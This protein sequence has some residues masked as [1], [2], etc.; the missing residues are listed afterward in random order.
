VTAYAEEIDLAISVAVVDGTGA[1]IAVSRMEGADPWTSEL[2]CNKALTA[3]SFWL[4]T[5][6]MRNEARRPWFRSLV[7]SSRGRIMQAAGGVPI[8]ENAYVIG[9]VG[10]AGCDT[11]EQDIRCCQAA[12]A[13]VKSHA[14]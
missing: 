11:E 6:A 13:A 8:V 5:H 9:A 7:V 2:A 10:V 1:P 3:T 12:L 4:A 14:H